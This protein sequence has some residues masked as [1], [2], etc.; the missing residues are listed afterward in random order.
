MFNLSMASKELFHSNMLYWLA[1]AYRNQFKEIMR[2]LD[3]LVDSWSDNW[4][5]HREKYHFD[6]LITDEKEKRYYLILENKVKSIPY[7]EQLDEYIKKVESQNTCRL[8]LSLATDFPNSKY[9]NDSGWIIKNYQDYANAIY[10]VLPS[11]TDCYHRS[12]LLDYCMVIKCLHEKQIKWTYGYDNNY[13]E[14]FVNESSEEKSLRIEDMRKKVLYSR[15][16]DD[17][18]K[19]LNAKLFTNNQI[20][21]PLNPKDSDIYINYGMTRSVGLL[22]VKIRIE[23]NF[24]FVIQLQGEAYRHCVETLDKDGTT[25]IEVVKAKLK[26]DNSRKKESNSLVDNIVNE[27]LS[28]LNNSSEQNKYPFMRECFV[29]PNTRNPKPGDKKAYNQYGQTFIY[30]YVKLTEKATIEDVINGIITDV[31]RVQIILGKQQFNLV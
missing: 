16:A 2:K 28:P 12:L 11:I 30:Q 4:K 7:T 10:D 19:R 18:Q 13:R 26:D 31:N 15:L 3:V 25:Y 27:F 21:N 1:V 6:L 8:L 14:I 23:G 22:D 24:F 9:I 20:T 29:Y 17:L 5:C